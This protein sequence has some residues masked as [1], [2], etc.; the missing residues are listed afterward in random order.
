MGRILVLGSLNADLVVRA[1]R[2]P[3]L[4]ETLSGEDLE[5][6][7]GGKGANQAVAAARLGAPTSLVGAVG[8]DAFGDLLLDAQRQ[9]GVDC[10][11][12][13]RTQRA[14]GVAL[15]T[16]LPGGQNSIL[17]SPGAN[18]AVT[19]R[20]AQAACASLAPGDFLLCQLETRLEAVAAAL[21]TA[22]RQGAATLLDPAP[23]RDLPAELV[24]AVD[25]LTPNE[26]EA[27]ALTGL[28]E[29]AAPEVQAAALLQRGPGAVILKRGSRGS[30]TAS[31]SMRFSTPAMQV[32]AVDTTAAGDVF[33]A[34]LAAALCRQETLAAAVQFAT[35][36][37]AIS[38]TRRG[39]QPSAPSLD[40][41]RSAL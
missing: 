22:R 5:I 34:A 10:S 36:A 13:Q 4:G 6:F 24:H 38:V 29:G 7:P 33:N 15:I 28:P 16:V 17:L 19:G 8:Q 3:A 25:I 12:V 41:V 20:Q 21:D 2:L 23:A 14:T 26:T 9:A 37:A 30:Y 31:G 32:E 35:A 40:E 27:A 11:G 39:A 1:E 18:Q